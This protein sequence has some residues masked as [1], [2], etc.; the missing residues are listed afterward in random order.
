MNQIQIIQQILQFPVLTVKHKKKLQSRKIVNKKL[1]QISEKK[2]KMKNM[3]A[4]F[5]SFLLSVFFFPSLCAASECKVVI[6]EINIMDTQ[7]V[8]KNDYIELKSTCNSDTPLRGYKLIGFNCEST[9]G[10]I[11]LIITLWN[12]RT[13]KN[14]FFTVGGTDVAAD[15]K[16]PSDFI[17]YRTGLEK[18]KVKKISNFFNKIVDTKNAIG[19]LYDSKQINPFKKFV[20]SDKQTNIK[21]TEEILEQLTEYLIDLVVFG[22]NKTCAQCKLFEKINDEFALKKYLLPTTPANKDISLNRCGIE[23]T[24]FL[25]EKFK[26]GKHT[27]GK[28]N[29]CTGPHFLLDDLI[30]VNVIS[31]YATDYDDIQGAMCS[32]QPTC[33]ASNI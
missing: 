31:T 7:K 32:N 14:G 4:A 10:T 26:L 8:N 27:P 29:D 21:I 30:P 13:D 24:G 11:D 12:H 25:P 33:T 16:V 3:K 28:P 20:L 1:N 18:Q 22:E 6:N 5:Y 15:L 19:L 2:S 17:K 9:I 23:S